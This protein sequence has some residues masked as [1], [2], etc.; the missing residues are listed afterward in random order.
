PQRPHPRVS[1]E[2]TFLKI[3][4]LYPLI[5]HATLVLRHVPPLPLAREL[6]VARLWSTILVHTPYQQDFHDCMD[7]QCGLHVNRP[8][9]CGRPRSWSC[10]DYPEG[11]FPMGLWHNRPYV[12]HKRRPCNCR[13]SGESMNQRATPQQH[14]LQR[15]PQLEVLRVV[16]MTWIFLFHLWSVIP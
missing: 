1:P 7:T 3:L 12:V 6:P 5:G 8:L 4:G 15:L 2:P 9:C 13:S 11:A 10:L 14:P 16:T